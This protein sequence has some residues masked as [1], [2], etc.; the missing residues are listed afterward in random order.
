MS[1]AALLLAFGSLT[2]GCTEGEVR[3]SLAR[4]TVSFEQGGLES[5]LSEAMFIGEQAAFVVG[6]RLGGLG[7]P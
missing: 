7:L 3:A 1:A 2:A 4:L 5:A 6:M